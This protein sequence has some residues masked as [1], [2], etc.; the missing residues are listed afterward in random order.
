MSRTC[1]TMPSIPVRK[2]YSGQYPGN[3]SAV[4]LPIPHHDPRPHRRAGPHNRRSRD[5][6]RR[7]LGRPPSPAYC[8]RS[9]PE[10]LRCVRQTTR[11]RGSASVRAARDCRPGSCGVPPGK[12]RRC[13]R[14]PV[15]AM[16]TGS[17]SSWPG[18]AAGRPRRHD[19][20][21]RQRG[22]RSG[23]VVR[24]VKDRTGHCSARCHSHALRC[25]TA[26]G[27]ARRTP[28]RTAP[29]QPART[30]S[31]PSGPAPPRYGYADVT[32]GGVGSCQRSRDRAQEWVKRPQE[33]GPCPREET[34]AVLHSGAAAEQRGAGRR[35]TSGV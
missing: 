6:P 5:P 34:R 33:R 2:A 3:V 1:L 26:A 16:G 24:Q 7:P 14:S 8:T 19:R 35:S 25:I 17:P 10:C 27:R 31:R 29:T 30:G 28:M 15:D 11:D 22:G 9:R 13:P 32:V 18:W 23:R 21:R 12:A 20:R 4:M